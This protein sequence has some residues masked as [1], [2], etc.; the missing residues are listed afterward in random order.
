MWPVFVLLGLQS[1]R[2]PFWGANYFEVAF[3]VPLCILQMCAQGRSGLDRSQAGQHG[4]VPARR[5]AGDRLGRGC[6]GT[7]GAQELH[8]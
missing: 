1:S 4:A 8:P 3:F 7:I 6:T 5:G 2:D